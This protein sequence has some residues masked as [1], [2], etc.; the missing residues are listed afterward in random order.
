VKNPTS[1]AKLEAKIVLGVLTLALAGATVGITL[2]LV[3]VHDNGA[4]AAITEPAEQAETESPATTEAATTEAETEATT[5]AETEATTEAETEATTEA[6]TEAETEGETEAEGGGGG[7]AAAGAEVFA[8][9]GCASCHTLADAGASG[10]V[11][12]NLDEAQPDEAL[13]V[14]RVTNG[15]GAMPSFADQLTEQQIADVAAYVSS[16][17]GA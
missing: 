17:A 5:E 13:V 9:A 4:E 1:A 6:E 16:V 15:Q 2:W 11:G 12:P 3:D 10:T 7:D 14:E 8:S